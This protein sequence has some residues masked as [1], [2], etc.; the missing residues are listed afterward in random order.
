[1]RKYMRDRYAANPS[2][3][4]EQIAR[5]TA[6]YYEVEQGNV[7]EKNHSRKIEVLT[8]YGLC[9]KLRCC[10][11]GC[12]VVDV[13]MLTLDHIA[14]DGAEHRKKITGSVYQWVQAQNY[15]KGFQTLCAN[16]QLKKEILRRKI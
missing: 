9:G 13:D 11:E 3:R 10:W 4:A 7:Q 14:N 2:V 1:M 6:R 5:A 12:E 15:P 16:H 8:H